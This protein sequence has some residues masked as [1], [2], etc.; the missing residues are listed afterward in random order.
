LKNNFFWNVSINKTVHIIEE[1]SELFWY[2]V[3]IGNF[4]F[5]FLIKRPTP[6]ALDAAYCRSCSAPFSHEEGCQDCFS[7]KTPRQ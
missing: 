5:G 4:G 7:R 6:R 1:V 3:S 2:G